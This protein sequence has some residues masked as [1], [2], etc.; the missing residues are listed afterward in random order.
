MALF[1]LFGNDRAMA[2]NTY[3]G[4]E[5]ATDK[6]AR[7]RREKHHRNAAKADRKGQAWHDD[8]RRRQ[9]RGWRW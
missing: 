7:K 2:A 9:D 6:A 8:Q 1:G 4:R 5:S 3:S